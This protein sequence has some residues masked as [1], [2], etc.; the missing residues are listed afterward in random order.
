MLIGAYLVF[1]AML[2]LRLPNKIIDTSSCKRN[3]VMISIILI[4]ATLIINQ[5]QISLYIGIILFIGIFINYTF[6]IL[7]NVI[8]AFNRKTDP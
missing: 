6:P 3:W 2:I 1:V 4:G 8:T 5:K 7:L